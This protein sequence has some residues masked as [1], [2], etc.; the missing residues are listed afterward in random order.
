MFAVKLPMHPPGAGALQ[1]HVSEQ[2]VDSPRCSTSP[3]SN[4]LGHVSVSLTTAPT[5]H[6]LGTTRQRSEEFGVFVHLALHRSA[7]PMIRSVVHG[8]PSSQSS[9]EGQSPS[10]LS[11]PPF[12]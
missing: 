3:E 6:P 8:S 12:T 5:I 10:Q 2:C 4:P 1:L 11:L 7:L 9:A